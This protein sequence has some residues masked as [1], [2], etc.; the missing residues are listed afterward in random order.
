LRQMLHFNLSLSTR[1]VKPLPRA[2]GIEGA[3]L[4]WSL[5]TGANLS[6]LTFNQIS[7]I[8]VE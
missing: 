3:F 4:P 2:L 7:C 5:G 8:M 6:L 1:P